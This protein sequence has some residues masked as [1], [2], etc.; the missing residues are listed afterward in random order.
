MRLLARPA[1]HA[2]GTDASPPALPSH[3]PTPRP[4]VLD[5]SLQS[6]ALEQTGEGG[7]HCDTKAR[8]LART[9]RLAR[10]CS[11]SAFLP[12]PATV[13]LRQAA[14]T[15]NNHQSIAPNVRRSRLTPKPWRAAGRSW[16]S[17]G[18][19]SWPTPVR[20]RSSSLCLLCC[21]LFRP[22]ATPPPACRKITPPL[23]PPHS[24]TA[25]SC[26]RQAGQCEARAPARRHRHL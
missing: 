26:R 18:I 11:Y 9:V 3:P 23:L 24:L 6:Q 25:C 17:C 12:E 14:A 20:L 4:Q 22:P 10:A 15:C 1:L 19:L 7:L 16:P 21:A 2:V 5:A 13:G 8:R